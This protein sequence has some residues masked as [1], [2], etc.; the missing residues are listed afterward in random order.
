MKH[1]DDLKVKY[2]SNSLKSIFNEIN[3]HINKIYHEVEIY[4]FRKQ[5][6]KNQK[7]KKDDI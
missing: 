4:K 5:I 7:N 1:N 2:Q 6:T 3:Y